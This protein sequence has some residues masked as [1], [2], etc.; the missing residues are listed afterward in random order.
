[1]TSERSIA[2]RIAVLGAAAAAV[3]AIVSA[4]VPLVVLGLRLTAA[5]ARS[6]ERLA[7]AI[8]AGL[9]REASEETTFARAAH[10]V[11]EESALE[12]ARLEIWGRERLLAAVGPGATLGPGASLASARAHREKG[13][14]VVRRATADGHVVAVALPVSMPPA[15]GREMAWALLLAVVPLSA[16]A[17]FVTVR[18]ARRGLRPLE[19]LAADVAARRPAGRWERVEPTSADV[20]ITHLAEALNETGGRLAAAL[21]TERELAAYA[22]HALRSP[23][24]RLAALTDSSEPPIQRAVASLRRLVDSLLILARADARPGESGTTVNAADLLRHAAA[25]REGGGRAILV[26]APDEALVR[27]DVE[28]LAAAISHLLD[29]AFAYAPAGTPVRVTADMSG[30]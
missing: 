3:T 1:M 5:D 7:Q 15:L 4:I 2:R 27:G 24:T 18:L 22:S 25:E 21:A 26:E 11:L 17:A 10:D 16:L 14:V 6:V 30:P 13:R 23:L 9:K 12:D 28:L 20:E 29:N 8:E 19:A